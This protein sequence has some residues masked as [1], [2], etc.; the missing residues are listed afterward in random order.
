MQFFNN[1]CWKFTRN[2]CFRWNKTW[3]YRCAHSTCKC[4][5]FMIIVVCNL[6]IH[7]EP[8]EYLVAEAGDHFGF[9]W[10]NYGVVS[11]DYD[12]SGTSHY[13]TQQDTIQV[14][15]RTCIWYTLFQFP[16]SQAKSSI[17]VALYNSFLESWPVCIDHE[18][19]WTFC[20][21]GCKK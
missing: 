6:Q 14:G 7:L 17:K 3:I 4:V 18:L 2:I 15:M 12:Y 9:T 10:T 8:H 19:G 1:L 20:H 21:C 5:L 11:F 16:P 13:C